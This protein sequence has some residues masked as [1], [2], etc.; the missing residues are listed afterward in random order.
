MS[1]KIY[2]SIQ[3][4]NADNTYLPKLEQNLNKRIMSPFLYQIL[5][6]DPRLPVFSYAESKS[7]NE[8]NLPSTHPHKIHIKYIHHAKYDRSGHMA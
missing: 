3:Y 8:Y 6:P 7:C 5:T 2:K 4:K 1:T